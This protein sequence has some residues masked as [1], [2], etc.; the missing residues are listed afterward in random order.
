MPKLCRSLCLVLPLLLTAC[1]S[2]ARDVPFLI[3]PQAPAVQVGE[4]I[5]LLAQPNTD[6]QGEPS[7]EMQELM[8]GSFLNSKGLRVTYI[9]PQTAGT[10][11]AVLRYHGLEGSL[12]KFT[13]EIQ[14][15][16]RILIE[17]TQARVA[18]G[19]T[20]Q[21]TARVLGLAKANLNWYVEEEEGGTITPEGL[22]TAPRTAGAYRI[23]ASVEGFPGALAYTSIRVE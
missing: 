6:I 22:Y 21:F 19:A 4:R 12:R 16:P 9:A 15:L 5:T 2:G 8:G 17:P 10:Y 13:H 1:G 14:V 3:S 7:W 20:V 23:V 18:P 11:R